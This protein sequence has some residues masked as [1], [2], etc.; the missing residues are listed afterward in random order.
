MRL[1][2]RASSVPLRSTKRLLYRRRYWSRFDPL[3]RPLYHALADAL[4]DEMRPASAVD[5]G[6]GTGIILARLADRG[7]DIRGLEGSGAAIAA[8]PVRDRIEHWDLIRGVPDL[9]RFDLCLCVEVAEH[10]PSATGPGL[11]AGLTR[12]SDVIVFTAA[13]PGQSGVGHLNERPHEYWIDRF[14]ELGFAQSPLRD[15]LR[16]RLPSDSD[17]PWIPKN[18]HVFERRGHSDE[19][20]PSCCA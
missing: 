12:L 17:T 16:K 11:V 14:A 8:S 1:R 2:V 15:R 18:L 6:C 4:W 3:K 20:P 10:L 5:I 7:V 9:G 19:R 13:T